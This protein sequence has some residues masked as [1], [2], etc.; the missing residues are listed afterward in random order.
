VAELHKQGRAS[1]GRNRLLRL[2]VATDQA[3]V[4][5]LPPG[6]TPDT[7]PVASPNGDWLALVIDGSL[8]RL[9]LNPDGTAAGHPEQLLDAL[10]ESPAW[11]ATGEQL[12]VLGPQGLTLVDSTTGQLTVRNPDQS[13]QPAAGAG[14]Q[15]IHAGRMWAGDSDTYTSDVDIMVEGARIV[16]AGPHKPHSPGMPVIDATD[17]TVLPGLIDHHVHFEPHKGEWVGRSLLAFGVTTV[18]EPGGLPYESREH[19]E[20]WQS[21]KRTGP[22]LVFAGPQLDGER[23]T[24]HFSSHI[25]NEQRLQRE[26]DRADR[27][28]YGLLKTY[29]RL[30][31][32]LQ[33]RTVE[34]AHEHGLP[35]TAHAALRNLGVG[36]DRTEHL[37]G[38]S[39]VES[40]SK[41]SDLLISYADV[42][43]LYAMPGASVV[44]TL[45][46]QGG[47]FDVML[48]A[49]N[50]FSTVQQY[51]RLYPEAYRKN[52]AGFA[53]MVSRRIDLVRE[54]LSNAGETI[55]A[56]NDAGATIVAGTDSPIFP[57][58][59]SLVIE[60]QNYVDAGLS[61]AAALRTATVNAADAMGAGVQ[62]GKIQPGMLAD[63]VIVSGDPL[64][65]ISDLLDVQGVML[66]GRYRTLEEILQ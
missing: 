33:Q 50:R 63:M 24:F 35:V 64:H 5:E 2:A 27:L 18:V 29:R 55:N 9:A 15:L 56:M 37:R 42:H 48:R 31:P 44:P 60:L 54:G 13:W 49:D 11:S 28:G 66:N 32:A 58:G 10:V 43:A 1:D 6:I 38:A 22:R 36:G 34:L 12:L 20:S 3:D 39:R 23:R 8:R 46:N 52:L 62:V 47:F 61:P 26:L 25:T 16:A 40:S 51:T 53:N 14:R 41:Q 7:G 59:L 4:I 65:D 21:G 19:F 17:Q 57:Y 30:A 45:I